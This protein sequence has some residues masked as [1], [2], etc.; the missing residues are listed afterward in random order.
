MRL[1][2]NDPRGDGILALSRSL[3]AALHWMLKGMF[4]TIPDHAADLNVSVAAMEK[5][6]IE[7]ADLEELCEVEQTVNGTR[8]GK[9][10]LA[11]P[12]LVAVLAYG[13]VF[14][15]SKGLHSPP[16]SSSMTLDKAF[17]ALDEE[18]AKLGFGKEAV[19]KYLSK[20]KRKCTTP[21]SC[22]FADQR[23]R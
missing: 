18:V 9:E 11:G 20:E 3:V 23:G 17:T 12:G 10:S 5:M 8:F 22:K 21:L 6:P 7:E 14:F 13:V 4:G 15:S 1:I 16:Y 2:V 19:E